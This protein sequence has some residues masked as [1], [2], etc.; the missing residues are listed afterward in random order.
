MAFFKKGIQCQDI[1][2][3]MLFLGIMFCSTQMAYTQV[4]IG[5]TLPPNRDAL[6]DLKQDGVTTGGFLL[7]RVALE[8]TI[9]PNPMSAHS[10]G[11]VVYNTSLI[12]DVSPGYYYNNGTRWLKLF[13]AEDSFFYMPS[14][15]LPT[16]EGDLTAFD[17]TKFNV[18]L[19][20]EYQ[21][22][23]GGIPT[24]TVASDATATLPVY[25]SDELYYFVTYYDDTVFEDV[26]ISPAGMLT[27]KLKPGFI[28]TQKTFMNIVFR[29][30]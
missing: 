17:G 14:M 23:Y 10:E 15:V 1:F 13:T 25:T 30:K 26:Q 12:S 28:Y 4:T 22:E 8:Q 7:P 9:L 24:N 11:M 20:D 18:D 27:Y 16:D 21:A 6:L 2:R 5:S 19:Y 3:I 29:V